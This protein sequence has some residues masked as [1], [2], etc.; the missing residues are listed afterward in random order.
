M[1]DIANFLNESE[2]NAGMVIFFMLFS[3]GVA[4]FQTVF[5]SSLYNLKFPNWLFFVLNPSLIG[6]SYL[7]HP[8]YALAVFLFLVLSFFFFALIGCV[9]A[10][11]RESRDAKKKRDNFNR[12]HNIPKTPLMVKLGLIALVIGGFTAFQWAGENGHLPL[13]FIIIPVLIIVK[14]IFFPSSKRKFLKLQEVLPTSKMNG[15]AM[16]IVEVQGDLEEIE[17]LISPYFKK[18]CIGYFYRIEEES[19]PDKEGRTTYSTIHSEM[20]VGVFKIKDETGAV[21]V[22]GEGL[23]FHFDRV[24]KQRGGKV[25]YSETYLLTNDNMLLIGYADSDNGETIIRKGDDNT[26]FGVAIPDKITFRNQYMPLLNSFL[27]TLF[28]I[29]LI[30]IYIILN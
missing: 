17:P 18:P 25:R 1:N 7:I 15:I 19:R 2:V 21:T 6:I 23:E 8:K 4:L 28:F 9:I 12:I 16:G 27:M 13:L 14:R 11:F 29:T 3:L 30:L 26:I 20:K 24:D 10:I 5:F 22:N